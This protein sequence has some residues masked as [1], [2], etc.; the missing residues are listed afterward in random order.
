MNAMMTAS[1]TPTM[2]SSTRK[3]P[4][5][6]AETASVSTSDFAAVPGVI[7]CPASA[8]DSTLASVMAWAMRTIDRFAKMN[9]HT[10][11]GAISLT[12]QE[13]CRVSWLITSTPPA[14]TSS[15]Y[16]VSAMTT[17][18]VQVA[19]TAGIDPGCGVDSAVSPIRVSSGL[20]AEVTSPANQL[21]MAWLTSQVK[22]NQPQ[23]P[24]EPPGGGTDAVGDG[25][26]EGDGAGEAVCEG[27]GELVA[28]GAGEGAWRA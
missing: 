1:T 5:P 15:T 3:I 4:P 12:V 6:L 27:A 2:V 18:V 7:P 25:E 22:S 23:P 9:P 11:R 24:P 26:G 28:E 8:A 13:V 14:S 20:T 21:V 16:S 10:I 17:E 19:D